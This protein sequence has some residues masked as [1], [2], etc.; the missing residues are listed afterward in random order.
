MKKYIVVVLLTV[1]TIASCSSSEELE[2]EKVSFTLISKGS[3][4]GAGEEG[5]VEQNAVI[6]DNETWT[7][8]MSKMD[9]VNNISDSFAETDIDF[10]EFII[11][12]VFDEVKGNGGYEVLLEVTTDSESVF[13]NRVDTIPE[14]NA[15]TV[16][17]Q[18]YSI[19][20]IKKTDLT[21]VFKEQ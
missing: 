1:L 17:T 14:G 7:S 13:V 16:V 10:T 9:A 5:I 4:Y 11:I 12:A 20:K 2:T 21:I 3:I 19:V 8:L 15:I 18:P 6:T